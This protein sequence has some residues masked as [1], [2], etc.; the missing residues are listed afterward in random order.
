[1]QNN[2]VCSLSACEAILT[3]LFTTND[4]EPELSSNC[5]REVLTTMAILNLKS[6]FLRACT[7]LGE[8]MPPELQLSKLLLV[9]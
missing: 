3:N 1:M 2:H 8:P 9:K 7:R 5:T 4:K 6:L